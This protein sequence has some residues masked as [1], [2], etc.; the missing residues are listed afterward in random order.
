MIGAMDKRARERHE[1][2]VQAIL[3]RPPTFFGTRGIS[4]RK[5]VDDL[6]DYQ[7]AELSLDDDLPFALMRHEGTPPDET[8]V[9]LPDSI[10]LEQLDATLQRIL[11]ALDLSIKEVRW[12][13]R[14][15]DT[16]F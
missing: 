7:V 4:F 8:E 13:R 10:P 3:S 5:D 11:K 9:Y 6:N 15:A 16:P 12:H 1:F 2:V 14:K